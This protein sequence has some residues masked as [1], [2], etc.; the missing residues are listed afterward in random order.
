MSVGENK[1]SGCVRSEIKGT[2]YYAIF[3]VHAPPRV[4]PYVNAQAVCLL[5]RPLARS[6]ARSRVV[7]Q[8]R[9]LHFCER[10]GE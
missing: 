2:I 1:A 4:R 8:A 3:R 5:I 10:A 9:L 6:L 7:Y